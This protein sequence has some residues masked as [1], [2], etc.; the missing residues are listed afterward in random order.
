MVL[1]V[2]PWLYE[3]LLAE[4]GF[5]FKNGSVEVK[6]VVV[7]RPAANYQGRERGNGKNERQWSPR[8]KMTATPATFE[9]NGNH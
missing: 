7:W 6:L 5:V 8:D 2:G 3:L 4:V 1:L 9:T